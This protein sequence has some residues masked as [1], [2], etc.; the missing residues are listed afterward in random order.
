ME[1]M[2]GAVESMRRRRNKVIACRRCHGKKIKCSGGHPCRNCVQAEKGTVCAYPQRDRL[3]KVSQRF[4][5]GLLE[6][7]DRLKQHQTVCTHVQSPDETQPMD[8]DD[9]RDISSAL[10]QTG[11]RDNA[12]DAVTGECRGEINVNLPRQAVS[13]ESPQSTVLVTPA[14]PILPDPAPVDYEQQPA[15]ITTNQDSWFDNGNVFQTPVLISEAADAAFAT[16]FRQVISKPQAP[17]PVHLLRVNYANNEALMA[18]KESNVEWP[19]LARSR[20]LIEAAAKYLNRYHY[21]IHR[22]SV[23][24][25][26]S[27]SF[28]EPRR[29]ESVLHCKYLVLFAIGELCTTRTPV[30]QSYP[31]MFYFAQASKILGSLDERPGTDSIETLLLLSIY[32]L[33]LNRRYSAYIFSGT[34]MRSA[35]VM[36][37]HLNI[38]ESQLADP[39]A[40]DHRKRL[41]WTTYM[42]DRMWAANLGHPVAIQDDEIEVDL[43]SAPSRTESF[44]AEVGSKENFQYAYHVANIELARHFTSVIRSVYRH[45]RHQDIHLATR[46]QESLHDLQSWVDKL[47]PH[48]H[49]DHSVETEYDLNAV[50]LNLSFYQCVIIATRPILLHTL[51]MKM[52]AP[53]STMPSSSTS[54][55]PVCAAALSEACIRCARYSFRL[56]TRSW[57]DGAFVTFDCFFTQY[58]FSAMTILAISSVLDR[59]DAHV[60]RE[61]FGEASRL[62]MELKEA[63]NCLAQEYYHHVDAI[64]AALSDYAKD[65][66]EP[67]AISFPDLTP[68]SAPALSQ[69]SQNLSPGV[70]STSIPLTDPSLQL[71][72]SQPPLDVQFLADAVRDRYQQPL[73]QPEPGYEA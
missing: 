10:P 31:G 27:R 35:I 38:P 67:Q 18:L 12:E 63:G 61:S 49:I 59:K 17:E 42:F 19:S 41:F 39:A 11:P 72:L 15:N 20:F 33:A 70:V 16:R 7:I 60:D 34:A 66:V 22:S 46:V 58:L 52:A 51:R 47:P 30:T 45:P 6:E 68:M 53:Q 40:R 50:S 13:S 8:S 48:L 25:G 62:L 64:E 32:S 28:L 5:D 37:L 26:L 3:V 9:M 23:L 54:G 65:M 36:G 43:P 57:I 29:G 71:L 73:Y 44:R 14:S 55:I 21:I 24:E 1:E 4:I 69:F 2:S 56:L